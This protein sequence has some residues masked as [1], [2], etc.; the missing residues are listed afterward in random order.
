MK[1]KSFTLIELLVVIAIIAIL[2][3]MLLPALSRARDAAYG[4]NCRSN[5]K[6]LGLA[7]SMYATDNKEYLLCNEVNGRVWFYQLYTD[8]Y[9]R[10]HNTFWCPKHCKKLDKKDF[11]GT[12]DMKN[13]MSFGINY[14]TFGFNN[15]KKYGTETQIGRS[16]IR[17]QILEKFAPISFSLT[18]ARAARIAGII[19]RS[20]GITAGT[21]AGRLNTSGL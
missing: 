11:N 1:R 16:Q 21:I 4:S 6:Q 12:T 5:L 8:G 15:T 2:A 13:T 14:T 18:T 19:I 3:G 9:I 7:F 17:T 20:I 10:N